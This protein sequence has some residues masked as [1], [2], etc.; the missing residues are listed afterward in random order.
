M[1]TG[2]PLWVL[3][4]ESTR[5]ERDMEDSTS[6]SAATAASTPETQVAVEQLDK[7]Q[8]SSTWVGRFGNGWPWP[9]E[10]RGA[11]GRLRASVDT[12]ATVGG[13]VARSRA[14]HLRA[15]SYAAVGRPLSPPRAL[16]YWIAGIGWCSRVWCVWLCLP[17]VV[18]CGQVAKFCK[19]QLLRI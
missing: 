7:G 9:C 12:A 2:R 15:P 8:V 1:R 18:D 16:L 11:G 3:A 5:G 17:A 4:R 13:R 14:L 10:A 19:P 6:T